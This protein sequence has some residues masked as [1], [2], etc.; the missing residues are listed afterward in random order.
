MELKIPIQM[1]AHTSANAPLRVAM[2]ARNMFLLVTMQISCVM[3]AALTKVFQP[4]SLRNTRKHLP[5]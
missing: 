1:H 3:I 4:R 2:Y 5:M